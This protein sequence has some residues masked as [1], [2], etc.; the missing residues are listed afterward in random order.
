MSTDPLVESLLPEDAERRSHV[1]LYPLALGIGIAEGRDAAWL[2]G[3]GAVAAR[4]GLEDFVCGSWGNV[5]DCAVLVR[6]LGIGCYYHLCGGGVCQ[7]RGGG[8]GHCEVRLSVG[9]ELRMG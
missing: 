3:S 9:R 6:E 2:E 1:L 4:G 7:C 8:G 5:L